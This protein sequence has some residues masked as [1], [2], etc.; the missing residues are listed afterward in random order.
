MDSCRDSYEQNMY[1]FEVT[2]NQYFL[3][4][5]ETLKTKRTWLCRI[6]KYEKDDKTINIARNKFNMRK[7][8][9]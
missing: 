6:N 2:Q 7:Y 4:T 5:P 1:I 8:H 3:L 9:K